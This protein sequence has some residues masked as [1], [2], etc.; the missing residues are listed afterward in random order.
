MCHLVGMLRGYVKCE[1]LQPLPLSKKIWITKIW[2]AR[3]E[4]PLNE[5]CIIL[6]NMII[7]N[8][9]GVNIEPISYNFKLLSIYCIIAKNYT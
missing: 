8:T 5:L 6:D 4:G 1:I 2:V 9:I 7:H 3:F